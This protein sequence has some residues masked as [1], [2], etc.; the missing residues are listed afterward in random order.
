MD[1]AIKFVCFGWNN[2]SVLVF[3]HGTGYYYNINDEYFGFNQQESDR[4]LQDYNLEAKSAV[5]ES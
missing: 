2:D 3:P 4:M 1:S 5:T